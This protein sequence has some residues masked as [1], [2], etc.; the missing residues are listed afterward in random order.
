MELPDRTSAIIPSG[1]AEHAPPPDLAASV[2]CVWTGLRDDARPS[3]WHRVLPDGCVDILLAFEELPDRSGSAV[4]VSIV[5][6]MTKPILVN[7]PQPRLYI[8]IRFAPGV[9]HRAV[10]APA[11]LLIDQRVDFGSI[12]QCRADRV[13][14]A[15]E[16]VPIV[17]AN[18][19]AQRVAATFD[20]ARRRLAR[21]VLVPR[22][23]R[24]A[25]RR[26]QAANGNLR[27]AVLAGEIGITRQQLARQFAAHVG[28]TPKMFA[29]VMRAR[30]ALT[31]ADAARAAY[32]RNVSWSAIAYDLGYYD[33]SHFID[34]FKMLTGSTPTEWSS[35]A[36]TR[37]A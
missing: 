35:L 17:R 15:A 2:V 32:P 12:A 25:V 4:D 34:D 13:D 8:G 23:V 27:I 1:Y 26:L 18:S 6:P 5:G 31:R 11:Y 21:G 30:A 7:G 37:D 29:R 10:G 20:L 14:A 33:Q 22:S 19:D 24:A 3:E 28:L 36:L 16:L 9:A